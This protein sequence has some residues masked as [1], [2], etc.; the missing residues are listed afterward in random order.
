MKIG[1]V[2]RIKILRYN[3][4]EYCVEKKLIFFLEKI[5]KKCSIVILVDNNKNYRLNKIIISGGNDLIQFS[6]S[7]ENLIKNK[8]SK[9]YL[10]S[11]IK[12]N[13]VVVGICYGAQFI[14]KYFNSELKKTKNH[15]G[16]HKI[17]LQNIKF[18][19]NLIKV[20]STNSFHNYL[21]KKTGQNLK[22]LAK[23]SDRSVEAFKHI[24]F[25]IYGIMW[26]PERN[27]IIKDFDIKY[28]RKFK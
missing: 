5:Y 16:T 24:K 2:P 9:Y 1:I 21:I 14:A 28:F 11:A 12:K 10:K 26:H 6:K 20:V 19:S 8:I 15:V 4:I 7:K 25:K 18:N 23:A 22:T 17:K 13:I 3:Q 27:K